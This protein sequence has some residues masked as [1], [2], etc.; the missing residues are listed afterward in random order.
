MGSRATGD[1]GIGQ[2][3][4]TAFKED[5]S[6]PR[7]GATQIAIA[8]RAEALS[9]TDRVLLPLPTRTRSKLC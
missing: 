5:I 1:F 7:R 2:P 8:S 6:I 9:G 3:F 4:A